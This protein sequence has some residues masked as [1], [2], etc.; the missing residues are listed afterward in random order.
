MR[1]EE[2]KFQV[3]LSFWRSFFESGVGPLDKRGKALLRKEFNAL[4]EDTRKRIV[5]SVFH[6]GEN[7]DS[8]LPGNNIDSLN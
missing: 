4:G 7:R 3:L 2:I 6:Q 8:S 5:R 1:E